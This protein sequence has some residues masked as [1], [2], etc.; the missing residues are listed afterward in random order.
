MVQEDTEMSQYHL[1]ARQAG[2]NSTVKEVAKIV[3][4]ATRYSKRKMHFSE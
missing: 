2:E 3:I 4:P 1:R